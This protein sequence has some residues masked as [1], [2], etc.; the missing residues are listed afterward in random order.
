[1][2]AESPLI[3]VILPVFNGAPFLAEAIESIQAQSY[4]PLEIIVVDDGSTDA[5]AEIAKAFGDSVRYYFQPNRGPG[6]ARNTG[7]SLARADVI[8][9]LDV[10][11]LW[12]AGKLES[13]VR[14]LLADPR[15]AYVIGLVQV[16]HWVGEQNGRAQFKPVGAPSS[17]FLLGAALFRRWVF[18]QVG[19]FDET[20]PGGEDT[21]WYFRTWQ[22]GMHWSQIQEV[23]L[24]YR[25]HK[26][27]RTQGMHKSV[28]YFLLAMKRSVERNKG[29]G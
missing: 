16:H 22:S 14:A 10:D 29:K 24:S 3:S 26:Q 15:L 12:P 17:M 18:A 19:L 6:G 7:L 20:M 25:L 13:Q 8:A 4:Q 27:S 23:A 2:N 5:T 1:M 9:F 21:D 28:S 11:D